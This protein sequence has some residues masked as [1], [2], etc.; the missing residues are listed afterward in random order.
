MVEQVLTEKSGKAAGIVQQQEESEQQQ[1]QEPTSSSKTPIGVQQQEFIEGNSAGNV[2]TG[3][4]TIKEEILEPAVRQVGPGAVPW[5]PENS[6][7]LDELADEELAGTILG[8][9]H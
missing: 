1:H 6:N 3:N 9:R 2:P 4:I 8:K 5:P 7:A